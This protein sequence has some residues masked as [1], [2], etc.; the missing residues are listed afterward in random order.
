MPPHAIIMGMPDC[1]MVIMRLQPSMNMSF[2]AASIGIIS[3]VMPVAV[4]V[5][6]IFD[7]IMGIPIMF[8]PF[9]IMGIIGIIW[10]IMPFIMGM[11]IM[12]MPPII[13]IIWGIMPFCIIMWFIM[14]G[15]IIDIIWGIMP[16]FII[17]IMLFIM[18][19]WVFMAVF[20]SIL[21]KRGYVVLHQLYGG[22]PFLN[23]G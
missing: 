17:G 2:M 21:Q 7:I 6:F 11:P 3:Q 13:G 10:G 15:C 14:P 5:H 19:C 12:F 8:M 4:M 16:W 22:M 1:I 20:I 23:N 18:G 9:C